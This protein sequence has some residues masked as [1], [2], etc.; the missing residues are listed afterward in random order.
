M[1]SSGI[2]PNACIPFVWSCIYYD[3]TFISQ[4]AAEQITRYPSH[5]CLDIILGCCCHSC[6]TLGFAFHDVVMSLLC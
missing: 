3:L 1:C 6:L 2:W 5:T 4:H